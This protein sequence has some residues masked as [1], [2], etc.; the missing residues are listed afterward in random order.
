MHYALL[1]FIVNKYV[2]AVT[3]KD[4]KGITITCSFQKILD[5]PH[6]KQ[7]TYE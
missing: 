5:E 3:L 6:V 1:I 7:E 4:K 2:W